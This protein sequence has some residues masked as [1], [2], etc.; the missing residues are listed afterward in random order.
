MIKRVIK[1]KVNLNTLKT[2]CS[3]CLGQAKKIEDKIGN[4]KLSEIKIEEIKKI[5]SSLFKE[6]K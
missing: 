5:V 4:R 3:S 6:I 2:G 1:N